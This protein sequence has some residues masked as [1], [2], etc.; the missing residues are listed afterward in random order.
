[1]HYGTQLFD[2]TGRVAIVTGGATGIG[3]SL[4]KGLAGAGAAVLIVSRNEKRLQ[5]AVKEII[6]D[7]GNKKVDYYPADLAKRPDT[8]SIVAQA[9][10]KFGR[11]DILVG[12]AGI[13]I[14]EPVTGF[15]DESLDQ[16]IEV[17]LNSNIVLTRSAVPELKKNGCGRIIFITSIAGNVAATDGVAIYAAAKSGLHGFTRVAALELGQFGITVNS[18][19]PGLTMTAMLEEFIKSL[20]EVGERERAASAKT[21]AMNRWGTPDEM[22][23]AVLLY[24]SDAGSFIT[25]TVLS[26][27]GGTSI[28]M[29]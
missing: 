14:L 26:V 15:A 18:V 12:N 1:M 19:A 27:D 4:A 29:K 22:I 6:A 24:A 17:M 10:A 7:T 25:G 8:E 28:R 23:G 11:L 3:L 16:Q 9:V 2:L 5:E 13:D 20:G 21:T